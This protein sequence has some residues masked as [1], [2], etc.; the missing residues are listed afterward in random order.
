M[1]HW[2]RLV[3][4]TCGFLHGAN[5]MI[6]VLPIFSFLG[7]PW[8]PR[9]WYGPHEFGQL[10]VR[11]TLKDALGVAVALNSMMRNGDVYTMATYSQLVNV[12]GAVKTT[13]LGAALDPV[14]AA[15]ALYSSRFAFA[16]EDPAAASAAKVAA[17]TVAAGGRAP[18]VDG[19]GSSGGGAVN[20][21]AGA[22]DQTLSL[23]EINLLSPAWL[24]PASPAA[25]SLSSSSSSP[26]DHEAPVALAVRRLSLRA[27]HGPK[28]R[29]V[30]LEVEGVPGSY[31]AGDPSRLVD[32]VAAIASSPRPALV[33]SARALSLPRYL[34][35]EH[36]YLQAC[37][38]PVEPP[39][40]PVV[41]PFTRDAR[42]DTVPRPSPLV[43]SVAPFAALFA[44]LRWCR[45]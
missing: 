37:R 29:L 43:P 23:G 36:R 40:L 14:G 13:K 41:A 3:H 17:T 6:R 31:A 44:A 11:S 33:R 24:P 22:G 34:V 5:L 35:A 1:M 19:V 20:A 21:S 25:A 4:N 16:P 28:L 7:W 12:F 9:Y 15:L 38:A 2:A 27:L 42:F 8:P 39:G 18:A 45:W 32:G 30:G 10:G 26:P